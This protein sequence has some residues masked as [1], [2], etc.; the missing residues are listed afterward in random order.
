MLN[1]RGSQE[2]E[3]NQHS[4]RYRYKIFWQ[5]EHQSGHSNYKKEV[6][7][8][9]VFYVIWNGFLK[10]HFSIYLCEMHAVNA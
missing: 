8:W 10:L 1:L 7:T 2:Q 5:P 9:T 4:R 6:D 3:Q